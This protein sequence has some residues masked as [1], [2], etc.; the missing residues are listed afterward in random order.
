MRQHILW[1]FLMSVLAQAAYGQTFMSET[2]VDT[3]GMYGPRTD[4]LEAAV[5]V[6]T[7]EGNYLSKGKPIRTEVISSSGLRKMACCTLAE[8][9]ENSASVTVGYSDAVTG[10]RQIRLLGLSGI[11]T[12]MLD[13]TRPVMRGLASPFGLSYVPGQWLESIQI[14]KGAASVISGV[15]SV[16]GQI[17][18]EH[19]KPTDEKPLFLNAAVMSDSK[20]DFNVASSLQMG[21][22]W[23]TVILGHVSGNIKNFDHNG[24]GYMDDPKMLQFNFANRWLYYADSGV[25]VR[26]GVR[27]LQ[28]SRQGGQEGYD[29]DA[30]MQMMEDKDWT[31]VLPWGS[32]IMNRSLNGYLKVGIPLEPDNSSN[33]AVVADYTWYG[34]DSWFGATKYLADQHSSYLNVLYQNEINSS[35]RF[36]VG[37]GGTYDLYREDFLRRLTLTVQGTDGV[38]KTPLANAGVFG[39]YTYTLDDKLTAV[40]GIRGDWYSRV[41]D[42]KS[43]F[44][45]SPRVTVKYSPSDAIVLRLNGG[46]G[47]RYATPLTDNIGVFSTGKTFYG[48]Y[49]S[50]TLEDAWT[51]GGNLTFYLPFGASS[52][53][54]LSFDYFRTQFAQ[55]MIVD[56]EYGNSTAAATSIWFYNLDGRRSFTDNYQVDFNVQ[57]VERFTV[58][59]T[60]R[61]TDARIQ[62]LGMEYPVEKPMTSRFK[63]VLNLQYATNLNKWVFDFTASVNGSS[64]VYNFMTDDTDENG[65]LLYPGGY[66]PVYPLLYCQVTKRFKGVDVYVGGENLTNFRQKHVI[67]G[68]HKENGVVS[69]RQP[70]FDASAIWGPVMGIRIY[71]GVRFTLWK[72]S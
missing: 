46:R 31:T 9:F 52:D 27:A 21:E 8:S 18:L 61:Y 72:K 57:P 65:N 53:T 41:D 59:A 62:T 36:T 1:I 10:A 51:F 23:S 22:K 11:Y 44:K 5:F 50:H 58:T 19:R 38:Q 56:Y 66:T 68:S 2:A 43:H 7:Q 35:H 71:A 64:R 69:G 54:Y 17:N 47:L 67:L 14:A 30:Y 6:S 37:A 13:E 20:L 60:F 63:G 25:Q 39:E 12:Q 55:Q 49:D 15:E 48:N 28:D 24:D 42:G 26:F 29:K 32:E 34:M 40:A 33:I 4:S 45:L 70:S 3:A 16:T